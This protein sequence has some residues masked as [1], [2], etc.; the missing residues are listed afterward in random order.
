MSDLVF[1]LEPKEI[2]VRVGDQDFVLKEASGE[3]AVRYQ[4]ASLASMTMV[5]GKVSKVAG[6]ASTQPL[7]VSLCLFSRGVDG[8]DRPVPEKTVRGWPARV[9]RDL[10]AKAKEISELEEGE[11]TV[12][13]LEKQRAEIDRK[14]AALQEDAAK[15]EPS[16]TTNGSP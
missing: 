11:D 3:A 9:Q 4:N 6:M 10:F 2:P 14:I 7:L 5:D 8:I 12:E 1:D 13:A 16:D 15:N